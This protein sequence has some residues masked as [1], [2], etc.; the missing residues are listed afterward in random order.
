[1]NANTEIKFFIDFANLV[2]RWI[3]TRTLESRYM[4]KSKGTSNS[5]TVVFDENGKFAPL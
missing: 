5:F 3:Y 2:L 1:M 4:Y